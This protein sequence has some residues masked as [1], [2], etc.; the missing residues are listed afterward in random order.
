[1]NR[2][3]SEL[4][5]TS[6]TPMRTVI[7]GSILTALAVS[8]SACADDSDGGEGAEG[9]PA[10][11]V[12]ESAYQTCKQQL[13]TSLDD[14]KTD[15]T[16]EDFLTLE[17]DGS[18]LT[19]TTPS[20]GGDILSTYA[21]TTATCILGATDGPRTIVQKMS[22]TSALD[23]ERTDSYGDMDI[24]WTYQGGLNGGLSAY[25]INRA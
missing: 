3:R 18:R 10:S 7:L 12:L 2:M 21:F 4:F 16:A 6:L 11:P 13:Q 20:P 19:L 25:F 17:P 1:M 5:S 9:R 14:M 8:L 24:A 23:G 15:A 22:E